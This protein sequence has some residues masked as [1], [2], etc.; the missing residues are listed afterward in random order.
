MINPMNKIIF[1]W[2]IKK[3]RGKIHNVPWEIFFKGNNNKGK[4]NA[5]AFVEGRP[6]DSGSTW[7][8]KDGISLCTQLKSVLKCTRDT[9]KQN[10]P[11]SRISHVKVSRRGS[12]EWNWAEF[13]NEKAYML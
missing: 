6:L 7:C 13:C 12:T 3:E 10:I 2:K 8:G 5:G 1:P 11:F 9:N 4:K